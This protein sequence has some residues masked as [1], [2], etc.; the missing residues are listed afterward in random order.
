M[1]NVKLAKAATAT[2]SASASDSA[3]KTMIKEQVE[4]AIKQQATDPQVKG[5]VDAL[6]TQKFGV[7]GTLEKIVGSSLQVRSVKGT[8]KL[9][10]LDRGAVI[11]KDSKQIAKEELE[12]NVPVIVMGYRQN[13]DV[14]L[15]RRLIISDETIFG[16]KRATLY[17]R[18][19]DITTKL[20][21]ILSFAKGG[22][23]TVPIKISSTTTYLNTIGGSVKRTDIKANDPVIA[24]FADAQAGSA[25]AKRVF[26]LSPAA[27]PTPS[28]IPVTN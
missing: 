22:D 28:A 19:K 9:I 13:D 23:V 5:M 4:K 20:L 18:V 3:T 26:T 16:T 21:S 10:E 2:G 1:L 15:G 6:K 7:V 17:G 14:L 12:L 8:L 25:S 11:I 27:I 24:V